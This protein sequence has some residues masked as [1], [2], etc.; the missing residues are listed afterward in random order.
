[1]QYT[2]PD[3]ENL[4]PK[5][6]TFHMHNY[7]F[8]IVLFFLLSVIYGCGESG[9]E[10]VFILD[11]KGEKFKIPNGYIWAYDSIRDGEIRGANLHALYPGFEQKNKDNEHVFKQHG[12]SGGRLITFLIKDASRSKTINNII[13]ET[14][15]N[16]R[17]KSTGKVL[18]GM[19][20]FSFYTKQKEFL[21]GSWRNDEPVYFLCSKDGVVSFPSCSTRIKFSDKTMLFLTFP[22][23][24]LQEWEKLAGGLLKKVNEFR[25]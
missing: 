19:R 7:A 13:E 9:S 10:R 1:M 3:S 20:V 18:F 17:V 2:K 14:L 11:V 21:V 15:Q 23:S 5:I 4:D 16:Y 24:L 8:V 12:W 22:K 6:L 25:I